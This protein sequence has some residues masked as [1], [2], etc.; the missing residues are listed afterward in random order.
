MRGCGFFLVIGIAVLFF[1]GGSLFWFLLP[2]LFPLII[3]F[4]IWTALR[5]A[6][7]EQGRERQR[8]AM[9]FAPPPPEER[10][11]G[12]S[13]PSGLQLALGAVTLLVGV[14][15]VAWGFSRL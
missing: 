11:R 8:A 4:L 14:G 6:V 5:G 1:G 13:L 2:A 10:P 9:G 3:I 12:A 15:L 7:A